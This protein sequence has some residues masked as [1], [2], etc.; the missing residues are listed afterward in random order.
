MMCENICN[1]YMPYE[2]T[3]C[4]KLEHTSSR[5]VPLKCPAKQITYATSQQ[6]DTTQSRI[7][8]INDQESACNSL[9]NL[10]QKVKENSP[11]KW[12]N[13]ANHRAPKWC[14]KELNE[15]LQAVRIALQN[16]PARS[17]KNSAITQLS[18]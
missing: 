1:E 16:S 10:L 12:H 7:C 13:P 17:T 11:K 14:P 8:K 18:G 2:C 15:A 6:K 9:H 3:S 4:S 5:I